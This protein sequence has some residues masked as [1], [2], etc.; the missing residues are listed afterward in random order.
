MFT[1][2]KLANIYTALTSIEGLKVFH[3]FAPSSEAVPYC[4]WYESGE[5]SSLGADDHKAEQAISGYVDYYT[6]TEF[7]T[8]FDA[9]QNA[10]NG[11]ENCAWT[12][13]ATIYGDPS[14]EDNN[15]VHY[16]WSWRLA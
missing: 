14:S 7:D 16:T 6:K 5:D 1:Q 15:T 13:E 12:F 11:I 9:I 2:N 8:M 3:F 10:L 4:V